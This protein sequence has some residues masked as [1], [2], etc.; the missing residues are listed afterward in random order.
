MWMRQQPQPG[1]LVPSVVLPAKGAFTHAP[2]MGFTGVASA[3][4]GTEVP[5]PWE[6][7]SQT[8]SLGK[9]SLDTQCAAGTGDVETPW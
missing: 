7:F 3:A 6:R 8:W 9:A 5:P 1:L 2:E 4:P